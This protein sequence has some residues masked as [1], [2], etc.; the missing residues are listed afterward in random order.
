MKIEYKNGV[1]DASIL[2]LHIDND[3]YEMLLNDEESEIY[4]TYIPKYSLKD[5]PIEQLIADIEIK[6]IDRFELSEKYD[7][8]PVINGTA[9]TFRK[10]AEDKILISFEDSGR[11]KFWDGDVGFKLYM[12]AKKRAI[13]ERAEKVKDTKL[14]SYDDDS[15]YIFLNFSC[16]FQTE[17]LSKAVTFSEQILS[18]IE[19]ATNF[20]LDDKLKKMVDTKDD[21]ELA[22]FQEENLEFMKLAV[23]NG[24]KSI[25][26]EGK[27]SPKVG[28]V[29]I[30]D[31]KLLGVAFR[32]QKGE[33]DHAE[34]TLFEKVLHGQDVSGAII[35]T[36]LEPCTNRN[37]H[38]PCSDWI[39]E[40]GVKHVV[41]GYLDPNPK[42]YNNG[43]KKLK[44]AG[45]EVSYF[46][47]EL[48]EEI[49]NDNAEFIKQYNANPNLS[50]RATFDYTNNNGLFIIGN[51]E[52]IFETKWTSAGDGVIHAYND[53]GTIK[54]IA[55]ADGNQEITDI[56]DATVYN[57]SSRTR[58][59]QNGEILVV[60][61]INGYFAAIKIVDVKHK[62]GAEGRD[63]L[64][65]E[66]RILDNK[67][68]NFNS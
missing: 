36:T 12:E 57:S 45:I 63:E 4:E 5:F 34:Y 33:G 24:K 42:I 21:N 40:K 65:F 61:N 56:M 43:C 11:R 66:Y 3:E 60:E 64:N 25:S 47:K 28:A 39:I 19:T 9:Y 26:E 18:Q 7:N 1:V 32:G 15:D 50:G 68:A 55:I 52:M 6:V 22:K 2:S 62:R 8:I 31:G 27:L 14:D 35:F 13:E 58:T 46:P 41:I 20:I 48:R 10:I 49:I 67:K 23:E 16:E 37:N 30:K 38:K 53:P 44:A 54:T 29:I 51:N 17:N 59:V